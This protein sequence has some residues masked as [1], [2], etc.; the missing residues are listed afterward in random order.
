MRTALIVSTLS[1]ITAGLLGMAVSAQVPPNPRA[2][3]LQKW[4]VH[5]TTRP[6]PP[7]VNPGPAGPPSPVPSDATV[8]FDGRDL[9]GWTTAKGEPAKWL[10]RD[11]YMEVVRAAGPSRRRRDSATASSTSSGHRPRRRSAWTRTEE[12]A[13]CSS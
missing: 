13:A 4:G 9:S 1:I 11:G 8:L 7:V 6:M 10:V 12:T 5:D 2:A 3:D